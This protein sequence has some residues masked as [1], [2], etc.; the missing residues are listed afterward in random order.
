MTE[1][2]RDLCSALTI[3]PNGSRRISKEDFMR[4]F[5]SAVEHGKLASRLL[6]DA[7]R[8][9]DEKDLECA[10]TVGFTFGF[11]P[12]HTKILVHLVDADWHESHEDIVSALDQLRSPDT[13]KALFRATQWIP[14]SLE[15][16]DSRALAVKAIWALGKIPGTEAET[17]LE[18]LARSGNA[19]LRQTAEK[20]L[21]RR[22]KTS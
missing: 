3:L 6:E 13:V 11:T 7:Y 1:E 2:Q 22:H 16:D 15:Y 5:P 8:A 4:R 20:Q 19:I 18:E 9:Q 14:K 12:D 10:L 17:K 21:E